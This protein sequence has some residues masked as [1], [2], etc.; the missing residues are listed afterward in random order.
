MRATHLIPFVFVL[1][2]PTGFVGAKFGLPYAE[3]LT[4]LALRFGIAAI[5]LWAVMLLF[6]TPR[7]SAGAS[8]GQAATG[9]LV[10][11]LYLGGV[12][13]AISWGLEAGVS[14]LILGLQPIVTALFAR[15]IL[16]ERLRLIQWMG[17]ALG[18]A[19]VILIVVRKLDQGLGTP[20]AVGVCVFGLFAIALG[21]I[22][23]K[24]SSG[25]VPMVSG[26]AVQFAAASVLCGV[27]AVM[28]ET[29]EIAWQMEFFAALTW[30]VVVLSFGRSHCFTS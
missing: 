15:W 1:L 23:Q 12:F 27:G 25:S 8:P 10:H 5:L 28:F 14:A 29:R 26:N 21:S 11:A 6:G 30:M 2:W 4:F 19:G 9:I 7:L 24:R 16:G 22:L 17:M 3:P 20:A 13:V 18:L